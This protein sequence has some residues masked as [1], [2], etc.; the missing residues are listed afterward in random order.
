MGFV[1]GIQFGLSN[2]Q[3]PQQLAGSSIDLSVAGAEGLGAGLD[4]SIGSGGLQTGLQTTLTLG[5]H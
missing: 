4:S 1:G 2:A 3:S 5:G